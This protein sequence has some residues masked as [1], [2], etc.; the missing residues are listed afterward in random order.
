MPDKLLFYIEYL[1]KA[2]DKF[3]LFTKILFKHT[4]VII[5]VPIYLYNI[6][7]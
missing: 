2:P 3:F 5:A 6:P 4:N 1:E 7:Y